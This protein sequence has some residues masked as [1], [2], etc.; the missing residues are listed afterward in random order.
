MSETAQRE[1][2]R[3]QRKI[4]NRLSVRYVERLGA[5]ACLVPACLPRSARSNALGIP[6]AVQAGY[7]IVVFGL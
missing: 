2:K 7:E 6:Q 3:V 5:G 4:I 1:A